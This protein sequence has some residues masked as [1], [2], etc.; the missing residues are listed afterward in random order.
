MKFSPQ[1]FEAGELF[2]EH[3]G[4]D[5]EGNKYVREGSDHVLGILCEFCRKCLGRRGPN[6]AISQLWSKNR[7]LLLNVPRAPPFGGIRET[8]KYH[9]FGSKVKGEFGE[10]GPVAV[11]Q[12]ILD[13]KLD[14]ADVG[15]SP[16]FHM[17]NK[18]EQVTSKNIDTNN[19]RPDQLV[20][21]KVVCN[22]PTSYDAI[23][24]L[25]ALAL[26]LIKQRVSLR[27]NLKSEIMFLRT[28]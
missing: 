22:Q 3:F 4:I 8:F 1:H 2:E 18:L 21:K 19:K 13:K 5:E 17:R 9:E 25:L 12:L 24:M 16:T 28:F 6:P 10:K 23:K 14:V 27:E 11:R 15:S 7:G 26:K 20:L